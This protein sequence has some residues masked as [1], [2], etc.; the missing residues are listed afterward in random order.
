MKAE[1]SRTRPL[2]QAETRYLFMFSASE[3]IVVLIS[4]RQRF[5]CPVRVETRAFTQWEIPLKQATVHF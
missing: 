2:Q 4:S 3:E 5:K 1:K